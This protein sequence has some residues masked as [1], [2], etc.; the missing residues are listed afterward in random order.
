M[1]GGAKEAIEQVR[2]YLE[3]FSTDIIHVGQL[4]AAMVLKVSNNLVAW[5]ELLIAGQAFK[6][7][8]AG[9]VPTEMLTT[10]MKRNGN[11][12]PAMAALFASPN[13]FKG[14][15]E[16]RK[17]FLDSQGQIGEKDLDLAISLGAGLG[18]SVPTATHAR[19]HVR[20]ALV[21]S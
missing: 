3:T 4:G 12:T 16:E 19:D 7:A 15:D 5:V 1:M 11:L 13:R 8:A 21:S 10:V 20:A 14:T 6:L 2:P 17:A 18:V 9:G